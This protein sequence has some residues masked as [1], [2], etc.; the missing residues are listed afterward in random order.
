MNLRREVS[1]ALLARGYTVGERNHLLRID[2]NR[3]W[4]VDTGPLDSKRNDIAPFAGIRFDSVETL[5][6]DLWELPADDSSASIGANVGYILGMGY[7][8]FIPPTSVEQVLGVID[9][10]LEKLRTYMTIETF[11]QF[12]SATGV[13]DPAW[14]YRDI[15]SKFMTGRS[16]EIEAAFEAA[17]KE[18][19]EFDD[20]MCE[21][22]RLFERN[23]RTR[24]Q[25]P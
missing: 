16:G 17:R 8:T 14:R 7:K 24:I 13:Y 18:F 15:I 1:R 19:C 9:A 3:S 23:L 22:F 25:Q 21:Q 4:V 12:W 5:L 2:E 20:E 6:T 10:A 11:G